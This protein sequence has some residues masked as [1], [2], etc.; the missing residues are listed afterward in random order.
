M[1]DVINMGKK[2]G[3]SDSSLDA[4]IREDKGVTYLLSFL[5][6]GRYHVPTYRGCEITDMRNYVEIFRRLSIP[7]L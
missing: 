1:R 7:L 2:S 5:D 3:R 6:P 4:I